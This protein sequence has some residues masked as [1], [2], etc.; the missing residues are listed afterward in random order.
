MNKELLEKLALF[1]VDDKRLSLNEEEYNKIVDFY[2]RDK[3]S[4]SL[5]ES[6]TLVVSN[7]I[8]YY[9]KTFYDGY[10]RFGNYY[11]VKCMS[12]EKGSP[13]KLNGSGSYNDMTWARHNKYILDNPYILI[14]GFAEG[15][16]VYVFQTKYEN[17]VPY[18]N[19]K[20]ERRLGCNGTRHMSG[21]Y[22]RSIRF[23][24]TLWKGFP[25]LELIYITDNKDVLNNEYV[26]KGFLEFLY[27][28]KESGL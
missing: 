17:F 10:D 25:D 9:K 2:L 22:I 19:K 4:S 3:N 15:K 18:I 23:L 13:K 28:K 24:Y 20:I 1:T 7:A 5:R 12:T 26:V 11:E 6:I 16:L 8:P 14:S 21:N 27:E